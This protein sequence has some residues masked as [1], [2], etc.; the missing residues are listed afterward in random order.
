MADDSLGLFA[1][2][3]FRPIARRY[4]ASLF[5]DL[6]K[7]L[8]KGGMRFTVEEYFSLFLLAEIVILSVFLV[9]GTF[10]IYMLTNDVTA[11]IA[12]VLLFSLFI[13]IAILAF[14]MIYPSNEVQERAK[15]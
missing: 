8:A 9:A 7:D 10:M 12:G 14:F 4:G 13:S 3:I 15:K 1:Y 6:K 11:T 5:S 2:R